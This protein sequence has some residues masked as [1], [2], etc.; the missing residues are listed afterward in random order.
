MYIHG[1][2]DGM[3]A[4]IILVWHYVVSDSFITQ[5]ASLSPRGI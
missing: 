1:V 3:S 5:S 4:A 2:F